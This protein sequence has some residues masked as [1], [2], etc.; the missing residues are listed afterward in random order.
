MKAVEDL[1]T[2]SDKIFKRS[3]GCFKS[4]VANFHGAPVPATEEVFEQLQM[5]ES[6][7]ASTFS[8]INSAVTG[9]SDGSD[10]Q[11]SGYLVAAP[12]RR[13]W[14]WRKG[15]ERTNS[16]HDLLQLLRLRLATEMAQA[17]TGKRT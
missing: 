13:G 16:G 17:W 4:A 14:D 2:V 12:V 8:L 11:Y 9:V 6:L 10:H 7:S 15:F 5:G 1:S 3:E